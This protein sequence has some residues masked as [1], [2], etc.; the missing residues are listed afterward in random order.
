MFSQLR[1]VQE[2]LAEVG[3]AG[4]EEVAKGSNVPFG[5]VRRI[6]SKRTKDPRVQAVDKIA[7]YF[8]VKEKRKS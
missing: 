6:G 8:R 1:Y 5:T 4:W 7:A 3:H 2:R